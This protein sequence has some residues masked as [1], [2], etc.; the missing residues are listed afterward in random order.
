MLILNMPGGGTE[1]DKGKGKS[2]KEGRN[3]PTEESSLKGA[4]LGYYELTSSTSS[5]SL[6][7]RVT[8]TE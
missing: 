4:P 7:S 5:L 1:M 2:W 3:R 8:L 6:D